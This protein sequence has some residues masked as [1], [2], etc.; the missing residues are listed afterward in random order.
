MVENMRQ[1]HR[2]LTLPPRCRAAGPSLSR[3]R[4][5]GRKVVLSWRLLHDLA[6]DL[7]LAGVEHRGHG[8][9]EVAGAGHMLPLEAPDEIVAALR[10]WLSS[11][12]ATDR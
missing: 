5:R 10:P 11:V 9:V 4:A 7:V 12:T 1:R 2:T 3:K 8:L 6:A